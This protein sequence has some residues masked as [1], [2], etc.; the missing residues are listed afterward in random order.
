MI[1][2]KQ[3]TKD[4]APCSSRSTC[5][6][7]CSFSPPP[8]PELSEDE[9]SSVLSNLTDKKSPPVELQRPPPS[10]RIPRPPS[11]PLSHPPIFSPNS[12]ES[13]NYF[14]STNHDNFGAS[15]GDPSSTGDT[16]KCNKRQEVEKWVEKGFLVKL[17]LAD[18]RKKHEPLYPMKFIELKKFAYELA[19]NCLFGE[20]TLSLSTISGRSASLKLDESQLERLKDIVRGASIE[21]TSVNSNGA[22]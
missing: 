17:S 15:N 4:A 12:D 10:V 18:V 11:R 19:K 21:K 16:E 3:S 2:E 20:R 5:F 8:L 9:V 22:R 1:W 14:F 6:P 7:S 13:T